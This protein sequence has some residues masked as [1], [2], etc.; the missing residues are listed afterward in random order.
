M[1]LDSELAVRRCKFHQYS[2]YYHRCP[3]C[4]CQYCDQ[5]WSD[6][7]RCNTFAHIKD[8]YDRA[9]DERSYGD[10]YRDQDEA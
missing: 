4:G 9:C 6:C 1:R 3:T 7:P 5:Y 2:H 8:D 10:P